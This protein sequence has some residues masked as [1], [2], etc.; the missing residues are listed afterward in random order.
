MPKITQK[1]QVTIPKRIREYLGIDSQDKVEFEVKDDEVKLKPAPDLKSGFGAVK[2]KEK[3][4]DFKKA[5]EN[6]KKKVAQE[7]KE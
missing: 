6:F 2:P 5:R 7:N 4:E 1:G 3:P